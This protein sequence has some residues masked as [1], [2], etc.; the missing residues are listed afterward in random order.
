MA[1]ASNAKA[2]ASAATCHCGRT[3]EPRDP[4]PWEGRMDG[5]CYDCAT[6]RCDCYPDECPVK[7]PPGRSAAYAV[8]WGNEFPAE[9]DSLWTTEDEAQK[10]ADEL[11]EKYDGWHVSRWPLRE[12]WEAESDA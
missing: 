1:D 8:V 6:N 2:G 11:N 9:V 10:R 12:T 3:V 7:Y 4:D 5:Y